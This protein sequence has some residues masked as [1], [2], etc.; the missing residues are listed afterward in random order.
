MDKDSA[1]MDEGRTRMDKGRTRRDKSIMWDYIREE[2]EVLWRLLH[3]RDVSGTAAGLPGV[4]AVYIVAHGSSYNSAVVMSDFLS[5][6][7]GARVY[8]YTPANFL[9]NCH[10]LQCEDKHRCMVIA[11]SQTGTS[12]GL[13]EAAAHAKSLGFPVL[14]ITQ[15][16]ASPISALADTCLY[17]G[18]GPE[19]SNAKTKGYS[20]T[21]LILMIMGMEYGLHHGHLDIEEYREIKKELEQCVEQADLTMGRVVEW[22][23]RH[24]GKWKA[25]ELYV[26]GMGMNVGTAMEGQLKLMETMCIPAMF[27]DL[28]EFSH[29]MHRAVSS[30]SGVVLICT[31]YLC[32]NLGIRTFS[33][34]LGVTDHV[35]MLYGGKDQMD[36]DCILKLDDYPLTQSVLPLTMAVQILSVFLPE[37]CG[38]DPNRPSNDDYTELVHTRV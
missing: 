25:R 13:L 3:D 9:H 34:L 28:E 14:G 36:H 1:R 19:D 38:L 21:L 37:A 5:Q 2:K 17:L 20:S 35:L 11:I 29:G 6:S 7:M 10:S 18:C 15:A 8:P 26:L 32:K 27:N 30:D 16:E 22:C 33:Y 12:R 23:T 24:G 31:D 4:D